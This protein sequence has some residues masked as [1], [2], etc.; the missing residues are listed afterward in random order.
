MAGDEP[1]SYLVLREALPVVFEHPVVGGQSHPAKQHYTRMAMA[2]QSR[3][4]NAVKCT[5]CVNK[6][7]TFRCT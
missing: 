6:E 3:G 7:D 4:E 2:S 1:L 5:E